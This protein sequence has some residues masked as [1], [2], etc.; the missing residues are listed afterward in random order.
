MANG[1]LVRLYDRFQ[2]LRGGVPF[3]RKPGRVEAGQPT[4]SRQLDLQPGTPVRVR[5][6]DEILDTL[7]GRNKNRGLYFDA[8]EVPYCGQSHRVRSRVDRIID[9][10][11]GKLIDVRGNTVILEDT[12]CMGHYSDR[13]M[14]CPRAI[15]PFWRETWLERE[16]SSDAALGARRG[17]PMNL[18]SLVE[19]QDFWDG[20]NRQWRF[21]DVDTFMARQAEV[22]VATRP[23][24]R[25]S[26]G[27]RAS[28]RSAAA[29]AGSAPS[30]SGSGR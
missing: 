5:S 4:P 17:E 8:E 15:Y 1:L 9:E 14:F 13:R 18:P 27:A 22:A 30:W 3:P 23:P 11:T 29:P 16:A 6:Y 2:S 12:W 21:G 20:W 10:R 19:Q 25:T 24:S 26:S 28:S 7:D